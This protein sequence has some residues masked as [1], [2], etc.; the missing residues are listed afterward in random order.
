MQDKVEL[1]VILVVRNE[2][3]NIRACLEAVAWAGE[4]IIIDQSST[5]KTREIAKEYTDKIFVT[6]AKLMP[7]PDR[8][9]GEE[10][11]SYEWGLYLDA[12]EIVTPELAE[13]IRQVITSPR[14][15]VY[16]M[17]R[18]NYFLGRW[19]RRCGWYPGYVPRL[20]RKGR[21]KFADKIHEDNVPI[22]EAGYL[23]NNLIHYSYADMEQYWEKFARYTTLLAR[24]SYEKG[25]RIRWYNLPWLAFIKPAIYFV[26]K[27]FRK[28]G[29]LDGWRGLLIS[30]LT[31]Y[32]VFTQYVKLWKMERQ[33]G[34]A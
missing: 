6:D 18:K 22:G 3:K 4:T 1:S 30:Y 31:A 15:D 2:E 28:L 14:C 12:D 26:D 13:E 29:I 25:E 34:P 23:K 33:N 27:Y 24:S 21:I 11:M 9:T 17:P 8:K 19:I 7:E 16:Y 5:D 10:K 32:T 20:F